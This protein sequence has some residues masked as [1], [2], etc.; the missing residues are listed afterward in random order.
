MNPNP[1]TEHLHKWQ[2]GQP[3]PN[4][5]GRRPKFINTFNKSGYSQSEVNNTIL[6]M[7]A[8][9]A[10]ELVTVSE[11]NEST[12]LETTIARALLN[13]MAKGSL[14]A[15]ESLLNRSVGR[16]RINQD[17]SIEN[18]EIIVTMNLGKAP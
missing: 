13:G 16:P 17:L 4:P 5:A 7:L 6:A 8:M 15:M 12:V 1:K 18:S 2:P 11:C 14:Y 10:P 9:S 3:S